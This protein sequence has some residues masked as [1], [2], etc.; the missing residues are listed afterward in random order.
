MT[1]HV[2]PKRR[3][4][5]RSKRNAG[6][7][8]PRNGNGSHGVGTPD[9]SGGNRIPSG[10]ASGAAPAIPTP[11]ASGDPAA[12]TSGSDPNSG[13]DHRLNANTPAAAPAGGSSSPLKS[14]IKQAKKQGAARVSLQ[15]D[16]KEVPESNPDDRFARYR[17]RAKIAKESDITASLLLDVLD[18]IAQGFV[19]KEAALTNEERDLIV[20]PLSRL[21][22]RLDLDTHEKI[23]T[24]SD[25]VMLTLALGMWASRVSVIYRKKNPPKEKP[26]PTLK[27]ESPAPEAVKSNGNGASAAILDE[28]TLAAAAN[29]NSDPVLAA[30]LNQP[31]SNGI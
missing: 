9:S 26:Q 31:V 3:Y 25:P 6:V 15:V 11:A 22:Q 2:K 18:G 8:V 14:A 1:D 28:T 19:D 4:I 24:Y 5:K 12:R 10:T 27:Q 20:K 13:G 16:E 7:G 30:Y 29:P 21:V 17:E 23:Q